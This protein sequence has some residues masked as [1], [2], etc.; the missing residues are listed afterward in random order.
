MNVGDHTEMTL[1]K[2][3]F[4]TRE[5]IDET[6]RENISDATM[7]RRNMGPPQLA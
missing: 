2:T 6:S 5:I 4:M 1:C 3:A 7:G